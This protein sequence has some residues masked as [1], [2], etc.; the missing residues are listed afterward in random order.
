MSR[1]HLPKHAL[2]VSPGATLPGRLQDPGS[3]ATFGDACFAEDAIAGWPQEVSLKGLPQIRTCG[4][5][6]SGSL[7]EPILS[8]SRWSEEPRAGHIDDVP[9]EGETR[10]PCV[11]MIVR[12]R[13]RRFTSDAAIPV[14]FHP[15]ILVFVVLLLGSPRTA[16]AC[17]DGRC[18]ESFILPDAAAGSLAI[19]SA[20][21]YWPASC[22]AASGLPIRRIVAHGSLIDEELSFHLVRMPGE[23]FERVVLD[24]LPSAS[25]TSIR[26]ETP[27]STT[28]APSA[29][30]VIRAAQ[31]GATPDDIA[32]AVAIDHRITELTLD[33]RPHRPLQ[34]RRARLTVG[35]H[36][37]ERVVENGCAEPKRAVVVDVGM[38]SSSD[39]DDASMRS[40]RFRTLV[41][42]RR[43]WGPV[44]SASYAHPGMPWRGGVHDS[45]FVS[46]GDERMDGSGPVELRVK[47]VALDAHERVVLETDEH[48]LVMRCD[49]PESAPLGRYV[50]LLS[51]AVLALV[52]SSVLG[53]RNELDR[54]A[55]R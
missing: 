13:S 20:I 47:L 41:N 6:A 55:R 39:F 23:P 31:S 15:A 24:E 9:D 37:V 8:R 26:I 43:W 50:A 36:R 4:I 33:R 44:S 46:C 30:D 38:V 18:R 19:D 25:A 27:Y 49:E 17:T 40:L 54:S 51:G 11:R 42:G 29:S 28:V 34:V 3:S 32:S 48:T 7:E 1:W 52:A 14:P 35:E 22:G 53:I 10:A 12:R 5:P 2:P 16:H 21:L 45:V